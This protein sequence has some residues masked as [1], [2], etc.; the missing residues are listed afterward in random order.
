VHALAVAATV[1]AVQSGAVS[2]GQTV[3]IR[4]VGPAPRAA[5]P[6]Y[7]LD[8]VGATRRVATLARGRRVVRVRLPT[9]PASVYRPAVRVGD[10]VVRGR[11]ALSLRPLR[12]P[13]FA[14]AGAAGCA[15]A[16]P[17]VGADAFGTAAGAELWGLFAFGPP[18]ARLSGPTLAYDG[19]VG[20]D[21][22]IVFRMTS[23]LPRAFYA[24]APDGTRVAPDWGPEPHLGSS[25]SR[26]GREWGAGFT[27]TTPGCWT[28][29]A[30]AGAAEGDL[31]V[32]VRS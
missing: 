5:V 13:G 30:G 15:P 11:G 31:F 14:A 9:L 10:R 8:A 7:L 19:V 6:V 23:G 20:K 24:V 27:F 2:P 12:P 26:P 32:A 1:L 29:H 3:A 28:I 22:K 17:R 18:G 16:S 25:W 21:V 4:V